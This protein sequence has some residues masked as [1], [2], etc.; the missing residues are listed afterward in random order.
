MDKYNHI[1][2]ERQEIVPT[3]RGRANPTAPRPPARVR[4]QHGQKLHTELAQASEAILSARRDAGIQTDSLMVLE[5]SSD[6][7]S[8]EMLEL[9]IS[10]FQLFLVEE[11]PVVGTDRSRL[12]VQFENQAAIDQFNAERALWETDAQEEAILTYAK[13]RDLFSCIDAVRSM[14]REDRMGPKLK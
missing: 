4:A 13:R 14:T 5:I 2:I 12:I 10:R 8:G 9:L 1:Q 3:Y 11:T 6:A 7:L